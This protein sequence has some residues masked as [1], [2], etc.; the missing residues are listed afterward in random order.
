MN[1]IAEIARY[2]LVALFI[3]SQDYICQSHASKLR[4]MLDYDET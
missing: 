4:K 1:F 2:I 3:Y